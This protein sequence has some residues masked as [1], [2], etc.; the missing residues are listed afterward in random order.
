[1]NQC[2]DASLAFEKTFGKLDV[3]KGVEVVGFLHRLNRFDHLSGGAK[4][5]AVRGDDGAFGDKGVGTND[6]AVTDDGSVKNRGTHADEAFVFDGASMQ[7]DAV[8]NSNVIAQVAAVVIGN[9]HAGVVL[10]VGTLTDADAVNVTTQG[11]VVPDGGVL[12]C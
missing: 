11:G 2:Y 6:G 5:E 4:H 12:R 10:Q 1:M 7:A 8:S 3:F 9:V